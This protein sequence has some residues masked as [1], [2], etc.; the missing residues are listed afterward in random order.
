ML[1]LTSYDMR[2]LN[3]AAL[4]KEYPLQG[5]IIRLGTSGCEDDLRGFA[6]QQRC[7]LQS[8]CVDCISR[9]Y[10]SPVKTRWISVGLVKQS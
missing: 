8:R 4:S 2:P 7:N 9:W 1:N 10:P 5:K 6:A 3:F